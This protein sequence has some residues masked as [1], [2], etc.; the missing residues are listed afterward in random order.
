[1]RS[2]PYLLADVMY[3][4][5]NIR[6]SLASHTKEDILP[7]NLHDIQVVDGPHAKLPLHRALDGRHLLDIA[8]EHPAHVSKMLLIHFLVQVHDGNIFFS[9]RKKRLNDSRSFSNSNGKNARDMGIQ[10]SRMP[11]FFDMKDL[12]QVIAHLMRCWP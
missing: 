5:P 6:P 2:A 10:R 7:V 1:M 11:S 8:D 12:L 3:Q 4:F 9:R